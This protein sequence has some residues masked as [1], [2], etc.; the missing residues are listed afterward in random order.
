[1]ESVKNF[2]SDSELYELLSAVEKFPPSLNEST[3]LYDYNKLAQILREKELSNLVK[4]SEMLELAHTL[5]SKFNP[6]TQ[7]ILQKSISNDQI[8][9]LYQEI[10]QEIGQQ[11]SGLLYI[12]A[13]QWGYSVI[14]LL[15]YKNGD[16][17]NAINKSLE[18]IILN[19][20]LIR[21][22][23]STLLMRAAEQNKNVIRVL[24]RSNDWKNAGS[25]AHDFL[26]YLFNG[27]CEFQ[28]GQIF[29]EK[30]FWKKNEYVREGYCYE[31]FRSIVSLAIHSE[32]QLG[33]SAQDLFTHI[34]SNLDFEINTPDRQIIYEWLQL[35]K[36]C[37]SGEYGK[38]KNEFVAFMS[39]PISKIYDILKISIILD[40]QNLLNNSELTPTTKQI[41]ESLTEFMFRE[42][43][44]V[45]YLNS[46]L[47]ARNLVKQ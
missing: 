45:F 27:N 6:L 16:Y 42:L 23:V 2:L 24:F 19:E 25:Y 47:S 43:N 3:M 11:L 46:D 26:M 39:T 32:K 37:F 36:L 30:K 10:Q 15:Y 14:A 13:T 40:V 41:E 18:C 35:K 5:S 44:A 33:V 29:F 12:F 21:S 4:D 22:G 28:N 1:M 38:F 31:C 7:Q 8:L 34:F 17:H 9:L 20:Y